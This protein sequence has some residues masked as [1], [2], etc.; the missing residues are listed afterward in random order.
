MVQRLRIGVRRGP[1]GGL[2]HDSR[3]DV[4][5]LTAVCNEMIGKINELVDEVNWLRKQLREGKNND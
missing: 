4:R 5:A 2:F 1:G 3:G